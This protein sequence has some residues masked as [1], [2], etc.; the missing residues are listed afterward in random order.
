MTGIIDA[1]KGIALQHVGIYSNKLEELICHIFIPYN[2]LCIDLSNSNICDYQS[3]NPNIVE[4]VTMIPYSN[5]MPTDYNKQN[6]STIIQKHIERMFSHHQ[7][8]KLI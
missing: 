8:G 5:Q 2:H 1:D 4:V 6:V 3:K 7:I